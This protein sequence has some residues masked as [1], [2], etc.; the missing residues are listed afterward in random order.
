[1][2]L[3]AFAALP[4]ERQGQVLAKLANKINWDAFARL[5]FLYRG[6]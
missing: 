2:I 5:G 1:M 4:E 6:G 3:T